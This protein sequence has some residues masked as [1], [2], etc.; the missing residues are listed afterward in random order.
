[1]C[2]QLDRVDLLVHDR[3]AEEQNDEFD[4]EEGEIPDESDDY[5][6]MR[7]LN[8]QGL[9]CDFFIM[10]DGSDDILVLRQKIKKNVSLT[11]VTRMQASVNA[12]KSMKHTFRGRIKLF[13]SLI[14]AK[15]APNL[16]S[17]SI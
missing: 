6:C 12:C 9:A 17:Q 4:Q 1:M 7:L 14:S 16:N 15:Q 8:Y 13:A 10:R 5:T 2:K 3:D 11:L